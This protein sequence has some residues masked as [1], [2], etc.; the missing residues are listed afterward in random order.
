ME[1][2]F[3]IMLCNLEYLR[4]VPHREK[5]KFHIMITVFEFLMEV[6]HPAI[7]DKRTVA[8]KVGN[9]IQLLNYYRNRI[10]NLIKCFHIN[11][12]VLRER[13]TFGVYHA[14]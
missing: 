5:N 4:I 13:F 2:T 9:V 8:M 12:Y 10:E 11:R 7:Q 1:S 14:F 3:E 6:Q